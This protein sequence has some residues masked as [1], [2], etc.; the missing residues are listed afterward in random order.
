MA[1]GI[2]SSLPPLVVHDNKKGIFY[3][4]FNNNYTLQP[5]QFYILKI[6]SENETKENLLIFN[7][8]GEN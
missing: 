6:F 4:S 5:T 3:P 2:D 7:E 8:S 1:V